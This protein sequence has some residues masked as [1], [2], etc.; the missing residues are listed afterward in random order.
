MSNPILKTFETPDELAIGF[1]NF[2]IEDIEEVLKKQDRYSI[3]LSGGTTP[4]LIY[5]QLGDNFGKT[6]P[7]ERI[8]FYWGDE[9]C[10]PPTHPESNFRIVNHLLFKKVQISS[11]NI[12][13]IFGESNPDIESKRYAEEITAFFQKTDTIPRFDLIMLGMGEDGHTASL[14]PNQMNLLTSDNLCEVANHPVSEQ[15]RITMTPKL[16]NNAARI[17]ILATGSNKAEKINEVIEK[18]GSYS[19]YPISYIQP[20]N[21]LFYWFLD[22]SAST[23]L[24]A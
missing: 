7:W 23:A 11:L 4:T 18:T 3:A 14:F 12:H 24:H 2:L 17:S 13:R 20:S 16:I 6:P 1:I 21:G 15:H 5:K 9:R 19:Q 22:K 8:H 10:V